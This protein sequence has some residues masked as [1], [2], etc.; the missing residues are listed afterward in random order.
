MY[1]CVY[2]YV[3]L[4]PGDVDAELLHVG[5]MDNRAVDVAA[6]LEEA[7]AGLAVG[8]ARA[9]HL[10]AFAAEHALVRSVLRPVF[11]AWAPELGSQ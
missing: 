3:Y 7:V 9:G 11:L 4:Y 5:R 10:G 1:P 8:A 6:D 2:I